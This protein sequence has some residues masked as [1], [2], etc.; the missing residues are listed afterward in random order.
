M[1]KTLYAVTPG[2]SSARTDISFREGSC[3][4]F[5]FRSCY[6]KGL[7]AVGKAPSS[8]LNA[9]RCEATV[10]LKYVQEQQLATDS[11]THRPAARALRLALLR[12][13]TRRYAALRGAT[14]RYEALRATR[15]YAALRSATRRYEA[16]RG[17][18]RRYALRA[19]VEGVEVVARVVAVV[20]QRCAVPVGRLLHTHAARR[21]E[22]ARLGMRAVDENARL[23]RTLLLSNRAH[24]KSHVVTPARGV[25]PAHAMCRL[26][27][28]T[29]QNEC[30]CTHERLTSR[31]QKCTL[32]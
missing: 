9:K 30:S 12:G 17:A 32:A 25:S 18:T 6:C 23:T 5:E 26:R 11:Q 22:R 2:T 21:E 20:L 31:A 4:R 14:R 8:V 3:Q 7:V 1:E 15:R 27:S 29:L 13:A 10:I 16:L 24:S 28:R 19:E